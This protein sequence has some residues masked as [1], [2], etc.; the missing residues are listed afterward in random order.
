MENGAKGLSLM[1]TKLKHN[2]IYNVIVCDS[3]FADIPKFWSEIGETSLG[4]LTMR[5]RQ[6]ISATW[7]LARESTE[8][9]MC[10]GLL[11]F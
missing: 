7:L 6:P 2:H 3:I 4:Y 8:S 1:V 10:F 9:S 11:R 5:M